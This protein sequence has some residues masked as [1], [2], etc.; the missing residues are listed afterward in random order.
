[1]KYKTSMKTIITFSTPM[2]PGIA[3]IHPMLQFVVIQASKIVKR[4]SKWHSITSG[5]P[6]SRKMLQ[7][8]VQPSYIS[9]K[10]FNSKQVKNSSSLLNVTR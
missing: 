7:M 3:T 6:Y 4:N 10:E 2:A 9:I 1:M 5:K 8:Q